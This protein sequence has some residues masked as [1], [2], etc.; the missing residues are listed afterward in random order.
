MLRMSN[1]TTVPWSPVLQVRAGSMLCSW[2]VITKR[3][4]CGVS[5]SHR[6]T[7]RKLLQSVITRRK[8]LQSV[9]TRPFPVKY[10]VMWTGRR[11]CRLD[12]LGSCEMA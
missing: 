3:D 2:A 8:L 6:R 10:S 1:M 7:C 4:K 9:I 5:V 12:M 11:S